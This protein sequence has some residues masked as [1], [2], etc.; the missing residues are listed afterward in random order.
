VAIKREKAI[1][2]FM[3]KQNIAATSTLFPAVL[4]FT[5]MQKKKNTLFC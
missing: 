1:P 5:C 2:V 3:N 4:F